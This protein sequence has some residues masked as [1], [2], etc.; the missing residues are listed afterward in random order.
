MYANTG[1]NTSWAFS[2]EDDGS[3]DRYS[4]LSQDSDSD[5]SEQQLHDLEELLYSHV[6]YEPNYLCNTETSDD[7]S[8]LDIHIT[9]LGDAVVQRLNDVQASSSEPGISDTWNSADTEVVITNGQE[10]QNEVAH[11]I[12]VTNN[13]SAEQLKRK[14]TSCKTS[15]SADE[16]RTKYKKVDATASPSS[17]TEA[18]AAE[19]KCSLNLVDSRSG[20]QEG[21]QPN[22]QNPTKKKLKVKQK[23]RNSVAAAIVDAGN[24]IVVDSTSESLSSSSSDIFCCDLSS[25]ELCS[26]GADDIKLSNISV[27]VSQTSDADALIDVLNS[28]QGMWHC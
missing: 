17:V 24:L 6:H 21:C 26:D 23:S 22:G 19:T 12:T 8:G 5:D 18:A 4:G 2:N 3:V 15:E 11:A 1:C 25:D 9:Q 14:A 10:P 27:D 13:S 7:L 28:L 20:K 16:L